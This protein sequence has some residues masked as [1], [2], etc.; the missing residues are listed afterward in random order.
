VWFKA[1]NEDFAPAVAL[2]AWE[3]WGRP[4]RSIDELV[5]IRVAIEKL[6]APDRISYWQE[7]LAGY[8]TSRLSQAK[9][10]IQD[11]IML[12]E[13]RLQQSPYLAGQD[14]SLADIDVWPFAEPLPRLLPDLVSHG[15]A[16]RIHEWIDRI[17]RR[18]S[19]TLVTKHARDA[20]WIPGPEPIRWG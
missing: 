8:S 2:L 3:H 9:Q 1:V 16:P 14:Y 12:M 17:R 5:Q 19:V 4:S 7:A 13:Q 10:K 11:F 6:K 18:P 15:S 20:D